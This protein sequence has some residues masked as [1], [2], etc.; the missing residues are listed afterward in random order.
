MNSSR[1][2]FFLLILKSCAVSFSYDLSN[3]AFT[4]VSQPQKHHAAVALETKEKLTESLRK[5]GVAEP[6]VYTLHEDLPLH[7]GWTIFPMLPPLIKISPSRTAWFVF[8]HEAAE[9]NLEVFKSIL[10][11]YTKDYE[12]FVG[13]ALTDKDSSIIHH[14]DS[15]GLAYPDF[16][17][18]FLLSKQ[19]VESL[20]R[21]FEENPDQ[22]KEF[23]K[24]FSIDAS[25]ELAKGVFLQK[26]LVWWYI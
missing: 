5:S 23:P 11:K 26:C 6:Q 7:G 12:I 21:H 22:L 19:L 2:L 8:L 25:Y 17:A 13:K 14:F 16:K 15:S 18:G 1:L 24:D 9:V 4:I 20:S 3:V 10:D